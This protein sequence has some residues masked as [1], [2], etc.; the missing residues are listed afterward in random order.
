[1]LSPEQLAFLLPQPEVNYCTIG[2][3][4]VYMFPRHDGILLGGSFERGESNLEPDPETTERIL[5]EIDRLLS[6]L[7]SKRKL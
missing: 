1:M 4:G 6:D 3:D 5:T 2:P 7:K